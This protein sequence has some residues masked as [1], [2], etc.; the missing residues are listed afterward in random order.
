M[1]PL[2]QVRQHGQQIWLDNLSRTLL[3]DGHLARFVADD[4]VAG[5]TTNPAIF[6]KAIAGGRYYEDDL[7]ALKQRDMSAEARY[8]ALVIPDVQRACDLLAPLHRDSG[9]KAGY[10]SLE[11][12]PALA[13]DADGTVAAGLRLKAAVARPNLLIKVP[14]TVAGLVAIERL[15]GEGVSVNVTLMFSLAHADAVADAYLR[16]LAR[17]QAA[18][19]DVSK[20]MSVASLFLSRVDTLVDALLEEKGGD[21]LAL[22]G[23]SA[24]AMARLAYQAYL[25]RFQGPAFEALRGAGARPQYMLWASTGTKNP[26]YS[27]LLYV[28]PLIGAETV[29][30]LP[31]AT[32]A[33]LRDHGQVASTLEEDVEQAAQQFVALAAAG[34]DMVEVG[35]RLQREGL[36]QFEQAFAGLLALT[37]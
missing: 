27:D 2:L 21:L 3:N 6:H 33:A 19:G 16:G 12:S 18:G 22:R 28:E 4:G 8:E 32:L 24:V 17:L 14:A 20:V 31:D 13:H 5:V 9:G 34:I 25:E 36:A 1:N 29:N 37:A 30:T 10:V 7:A 35:E 26:A 15:I 11:V 23:Q